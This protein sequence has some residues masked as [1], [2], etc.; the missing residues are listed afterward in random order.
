M[1]ATDRDSLRELNPSDL[2]LLERRFRTM[3]VE[4]EVK[5]QSSLSDKHWDLVKWMFTF[6]GVYVVWTVTVLVIIVAAIRR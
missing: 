6:F 3:L 5:L 4:H 2:G 1:F